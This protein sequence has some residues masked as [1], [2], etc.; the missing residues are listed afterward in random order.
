MV[1]NWMRIKGR[2]F[3][4]EKFWLCL[5]KAARRELCGLPPCNAKRYQQP[6]NAKAKNNKYSPAQVKRERDDQTVSFKANSDGEG[7]GESI[8]FA[9]LKCC[10]YCNVVGR[11]IAQGYQLC[12]YWQEPGRT[13]N[14]LI[15]QQRDHWGIERN[16][17]GLLLGHPPSFIH[18]RQRSS[19]CMFSDFGEAL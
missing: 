6:A 9:F 16:L 13:M 5:N 17:K 12:K 4:S 1:D 18:C 19:S 3:Y 8:F 11:S 10:R 2:K 7:I 15:C 14:Y